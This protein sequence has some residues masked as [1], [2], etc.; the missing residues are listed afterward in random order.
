MRV[1]I[2]NISGVDFWTSPHP[3]GTDVTFLVGPD[4]AELVKQHLRK[5]KITIKVA[6]TFIDNF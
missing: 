2:Q 3:N 6:S 4:Q 1:N 5:Q